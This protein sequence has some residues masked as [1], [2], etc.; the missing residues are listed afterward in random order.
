METE[1]LSLKKEELNFVVSDIYNNPKA[2][3]IEFYEII[4]IDLII[5][6]LIVFILNRKKIKL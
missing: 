2:V 6:L 3:K 1:K 5:L 4:I